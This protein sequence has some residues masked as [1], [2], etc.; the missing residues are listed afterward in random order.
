MTQ[1]IIGSSGMPGF[2][3]TMP[4]MA[5]RVRVATARR[6]LGTRLAAIRWGRLL[7]LGLITALVVA[8]GA[9]A[10]ARAGA[11]P[12]TPLGDGAVVQR[13]PALVEHTVA[14]GDTIWALAVA[15]APSADPRETVD[16]IMRLNGLTG[17]E[18]QIGQVVLLPNAS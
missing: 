7:A 18:V 5:P 14:P 8:A 16:R 6:S 15:A 2:S 12:A 4:E 11:R 10:V 1:M 17:P 3:P 13:A 9:V